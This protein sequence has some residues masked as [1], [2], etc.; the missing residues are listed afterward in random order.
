[1]SIKIITFLFS[2]LAFVNVQAA[3]DLS[4][5]V[6]QQNPDG[7]F[8]AQN[9]I[10]YQAQN[11]SEVLQTLHLL[12]DINL[13]DENLAL[14]IINLSD[15][16]YLENIARGIVAYKN[17]G[18]DASVLVAQLKLFINEDGGFGSRIGYQSTVLDTA[19]A[20]RALAV[21][22]SLLDDDFSYAVSY[23]IDFQ[24]AD[25]SWAGAGNLSSVYIT[26]STSLALF[27]AQTTFNV[28][29][30]I[31]AAN[32]FL[33]DHIQNN[34][35]DIETFEVALAVLSIAPTTSDKVPYTFLVDRLLQTRDVDGSWTQDIY[36]TALAM[37]ALYLNEQV[38][39][40][41]E[42]LSSVVTS[43][44]SISAVT[45]VITDGLSGQVLSGAI[46]SVTTADGNN[47]NAVTDVDGRYAISNLFPG[48][49]SISV[50]LAGYHTA[51]AAPVL[52]AGV[53]HRF[54]PALALQ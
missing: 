34:I 29:D 15:L 46:V 38:V 36:T 21:S 14:Q 33:I 20:V 11:A 30:K 4:W 12:G 53:I 25:G 2:L 27:K 50:D 3:V 48:S 10:G 13:V 41:N 54:N 5:L 26:T 51:T 19:L 17:A 31:N 40:V 24:N 8:T 35:A 16:A 44:S 43:G 7:S 22:G 45:G 37:R 23:L 32:A 49:A 47:T 28:T 6:S 1:M 42:D 39:P 9:D 18:I 52:L